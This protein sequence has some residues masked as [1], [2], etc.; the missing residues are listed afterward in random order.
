MEEKRCH[1]EKEL[2]DLRVEIIVL[3]RENKGIKE[4]VKDMK[5]EIKD[6][7]KSI[8]TLCTKIDQS[9]IDTL[10]EL[11]KNNKWFIG[12]GM[13]LIANLLS[14]LALFMK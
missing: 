11:A 9:K 8:S 7:K 13:G 4:D 2:Q 12:L 5:D 3:Q 1:K 14:L 10:Q 6:I